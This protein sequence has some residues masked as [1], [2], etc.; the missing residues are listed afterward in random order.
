VYAGAWYT[1]V[2][3]SQEVSVFSL[4]YSA[5]VFVPD[6]DT[7]GH[8]AELTREGHMSGTNNKTGSSTAMF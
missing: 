3:R 6:M 4:P 8:S 1:E 5:L 7:A 2:K